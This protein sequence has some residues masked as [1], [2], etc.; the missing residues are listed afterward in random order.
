MGNV[1]K[2]TDEQIKK[3]GNIG[4]PKKKVTLLCAVCHKEFE[5]YAYD[6][7]RGAKYCSVQCHHQVLKKTIPFEVLEFLYVQLGY[8]LKKTSIVLGCSDKTV[9]RQIIGANIKLR[10]PGESQT[11]GQTGKKHSKAWNNAISR[12]HKGKIC[13]YMVGR[14]NPIFKNSSSGNYAKGGIRDDLGHYV[15][16]SWEANVARYLKFLIEKGEI[17]KYE[18]E[19]DTFCFELIKRGNRSYTPDFKITE[20]NDSVLYWEVKGWM[21]KSSKVKLKRMAKYYPHIKIVLIE[22]K[23]YDEIKKWKRLIP[24]WED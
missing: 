14:K 11:L 9:K 3:K 13:N 23:Q 19:P 22:K 6:V 2:A 20:K 10:S 4:R 21:D 17:K 1:K 18:Y 8:S 7:K 12:G 16:S 15:R 24:Y 5:K